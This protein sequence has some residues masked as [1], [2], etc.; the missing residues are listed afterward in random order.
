LSFL[1]YFVHSFFISLQADLIVER[2][3]LPQEMNA[4][5]STR[6]PFFTFSTYFDFVPTEKISFIP[7]FFFRVAQPSFFCRRTSE[8]PTCNATRLHSLGNVCAVQL[9]SVFMYWFF[10]LW[11]KALRLDLDS[12]RH[13]II[14]TCDCDCD[15]HHDS[16]E[17]D[18]SNLVFPRFETSE[19]RFSFICRCSSFFFS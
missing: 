15:C 14:D 7:I 12:P 3:R 13:R 17:F 9:V 2:H 10:S 8:P 19:A 4:I 1:F 11:R 5:D 16:F 18:H 6:F